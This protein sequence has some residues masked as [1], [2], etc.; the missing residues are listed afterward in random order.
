[1]QRYFLDEPY[2]PQER[3]VIE[4]EAYHHMVRVMRMAVKDQVYLAFNDQIAIIAE[5]NEMNENEVFLVEVA[6]ESVQKE[7][8][9][10][11]TIASG[12]PKGD[13]LDWIVQKGTELGAHGFVGFPAAASVVKWDAKKRK[14]RQ[15]RLIK[16]AQEA[17]EQSHRQVVP[18]V[19]LMETEKEFYETLSSYDVL[20]IAYEESA[21]QGEAANLAKILQSVL[22]GTR[23]LAVFGPEGGLSPKEVAYFEA[24]GGILCGLGPRILRTETAPLYLL[25]AASFQLELQAPSK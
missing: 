25:S 18:Q 14:K 3:F 4:D 12:Y 8:P 19:S 15:E 7:L 9:C 10:K 16:I 13:K 11:I 2:R 21:K 20:L 5:I 24:Q 17:A 1:M 6:K 23:I 22:P